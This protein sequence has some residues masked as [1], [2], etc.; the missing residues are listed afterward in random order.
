MIIISSLANITRQ[1]IQSCLMKNGTLLGL[2]GAETLFSNLS[3]LV[4]REFWVA[5]RYCLSALRGGASRRGELAGKA[6]LSSEQQRLRRQLTTS[7]GLF[8]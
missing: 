8:L 2:L 6:E 7:L 5:V 1:W 4:S 3:L